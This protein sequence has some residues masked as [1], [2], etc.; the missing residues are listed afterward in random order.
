MF[1]IWLCRLVN[2]VSLNVDY[3]LFI[4]ELSNVIDVKLGDSH[5][6]VPKLASTI[7]KIKKKETLKY[8]INCIIIH[9]Y[10]MSQND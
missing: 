2:S 4:G 3:L 9:H 7:R 10:I 5:P 6:K 1:F 8:Q